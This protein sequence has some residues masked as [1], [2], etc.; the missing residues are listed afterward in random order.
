MNKLGMVITAAIS[1]A[2]TGCGGAQTSWETEE[3]AVASDRLMADSVEAA[4]AVE[5]DAGEDASIRLEL[6]TKEGKPVE[7]FDLNHEKLLHL[8]VVSKDLS[9]F[10]HIHP[11]YKGEGVFEISNVFPAGGAY[12]LI[13]DFKPTDGD[14]MTKLTWAEV[15]GAPAA[16]QAVVPSESLNSVVAGKRVSLAAEGL[17][18]DEEATLTFAIADEASGEPI[19]DLEPYLG[20][21]GHVVVLSEDG[22]RYVHVHAE[23]DQGTGPEAKFETTF[24]KAGIYKIWGQF[25]HRGE[26]FTVD[27]VVN[28]EKRS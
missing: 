22:E 8:I 12:R 24:P 13:A 17:V 20:A 25:Q 23:A 28:V 6:A 27:Y 7:A 16:P 14:A 2:L 21:I 15:G 9:Y 19:S 3:V 10:N 1:L 26:V 5:G 18:E 11:E 4:W